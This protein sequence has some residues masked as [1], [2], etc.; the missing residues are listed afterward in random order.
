MSLAARDWAWS[1]RGLTLALRCI[2]LALAEHADEEGRCW[3]SLTRLAAL[4]EADRRTVT[5]G[6]A[7]LE[8]RGLLA[9][10][11][12][13]G[14]G[15]IYTLAIGRPS[16]A[17]LPAEPPDPPDTDVTS[18]GPADFPARGVMP[19]DPASEATSAMLLTGAKDPETR[20]ITPLQQ[21][22][23]TPGDMTPPRARDPQSRGE[24]PLGRGLTPPD[25]GASDPPNR[26]KNRQRT[27]SEPSLCGDDI[28]Q[29]PNCST[30]GRT[31]ATAIPPN[32][33]PGE[34]VFDWA[35]KRGMT[36][37]W[38]QAQI[39]EFLV[40]WTD[41]GGRSQELGRDLHQSSA[42]PAG[43]PTERPSP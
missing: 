39:E 6:L 18:T 17:V 26:H 30:D 11:R 5:R 3:P 13:P 24:T 31:K 14:K 42:D 8:A 12:R 34:R 21:G 16:T 15:T 25:P 33:Q 22:C 43:Q 36:R 27:E 32:W 23:G 19:L 40:Y 20:G 10:E 29:S 35:A 4:T 28:T 9:R 41:T 1:C 2:L 38:V 7:E 37:T